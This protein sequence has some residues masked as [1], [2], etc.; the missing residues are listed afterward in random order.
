MPMYAALALLVI[1]LVAEPIGSIIA[2]KFPM[3]K[4]GSDKYRS[5]KYL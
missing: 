3:V 4:G 5:S 1:I 2:K